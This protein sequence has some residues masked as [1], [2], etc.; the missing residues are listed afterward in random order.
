[1]AQGGH[2]DTL[3][4]EAQGVATLSMA[5]GSKDSL[6]VLDVDPD[7][8]PGTPSERAMLSLTGV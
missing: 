5:V 2:E 7:S 8:D 6:P 3:V 4:P 1:M